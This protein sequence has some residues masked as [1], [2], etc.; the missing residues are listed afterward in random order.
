MAPW[1]V[2]GL[3]AV[4]LLL[5]ILALYG[6]HREMRN[7]PHLDKRPFEY[8]PVLWAEPG[9]WWKVPVYRVERLLFVDFASTGGVFYFFSAWLLFHLVKETYKDAWLVPS[10]LLALHALACFNFALPKYRSDIVGAIIALLHG[11]ARRLAGPTYPS[12][13]P[14]APPVQT[15]LP[16]PPGGT[17]TT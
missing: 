1:E 3:I 17:K 15:N 14:V 16:A 13:K 11:A 7:R 5:A 9:S 8:E 12:D 2:C 6:G 4:A 10:V